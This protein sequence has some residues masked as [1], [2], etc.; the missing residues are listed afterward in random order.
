MLTA[1]LAARNILA[2]EPSSVTPSV[3]EH[4]L[5]GVN[6]ERSY[7]EDFTVEEA[8]EKARVL[9]SRRAVSD[10]VTPS[11]NEAVQVGS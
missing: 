1:L 3:W 11:S 10:A 8:K 4:D 9:N 7:H 6:V 5:W 2:D